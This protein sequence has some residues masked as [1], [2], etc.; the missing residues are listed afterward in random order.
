ME[1][2]I[3]NR[4]FTHFHPTLCQCPDSRLLVTFWGRLDNRGDIAA[5]LNLPQDDANILSD[6]QMVL[7]GWHRWGETLPEKLVGDFAFA[8]LDP[9]NNKCFLARDPVGAKPLYYYSDA[10]AFFFST[11]A[12]ACYTLKAARPKTRLDWL[13]LYLGNVSR[14]TRETALEN[15]YKLLPGHSLLVDGNGQ[16]TMR[17]WHFWRDDPPFA[18]KREDSWVNAYKAQFEEAVRCRMISSYPIG[19]ENSG[20]LDSSSVT[21]CVAHL[22]GDPKDRLHSFSYALA[23]LEPT[24]ILSLGRYCGIRYNHI[25]SVYWEADDEL[26]DR[27][28]AVLGYP[29]EP[30]M[31]TKHA[32]FYQQCALYG[33]RTLFS[34]SGGDEAATCPGQHLPH[35]LWDGA[36]YRQL[37]EGIHGSLLL[38]PI[39]MA[40]EVIRLRRPV[41]YNKSFLS[42]WRSRWSHCLLRPEVIQ[43]LDIQSRY[44]DGARWD[45]PFRRINDFVVDQIRSAQLAVRLENGT[46][47]AGSFGVEYRWPM[48]DS[49]LIQRYLSTPSIEKRGPKGVNRYLH[50][51]AMADF[52][53]PGYAWEAVKDLGFADVLNHQQSV[54]IVHMA[55]LAQQVEEGLHP[56]LDALVDRNKLREYIL[57]AKK[58]NC[59]RAFSVAFFMNIRLLRIANRWLHHG[60]VTID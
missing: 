56:A 53:P 52:V 26:V 36:L 2:Q 22:L 28:L 23:T 42:A 54:G 47:L 7:Q 6:A 19:S 17:Q 14:S 44:F 46:L 29:E 39:R 30:S 38:R 12:A 60:A 35:E 31:A 4:P 16:L 24:R 5:K 27:S 13:S 8:I 45:A 18:T 40:K 58:G 55:A 50:R 49:R 34:G 57:I 3:R 59:E 51:R 9:L 41:E 10:R 33:I 37:W 20:G 21:A 48:L 43:R 25:L 15:V 1:V 11:T 32:P